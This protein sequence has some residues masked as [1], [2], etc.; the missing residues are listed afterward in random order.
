MCS[1]DLPKQ[2]IANN[3]EKR[4][5]S[6]SISVFFGQQG[7][8]QSGQDFSRRTIHLNKALSFSKSLE[9]TK[10]PENPIYTTMFN[11]LK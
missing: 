7:H 2:L 3:I 1:S 10:T 4:K 9:M 8:D 11:L 5:L 6:V